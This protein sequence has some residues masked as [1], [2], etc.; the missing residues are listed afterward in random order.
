M[1]KKWLVTLHCTSSTGVGRGPRGCFILQPSGWKDL[2]ETPSK[3]QNKSPS[4]YTNCGVCISLER[5]VCLLEESFLLTPKIPSNQKLVFQ[6]LINYHDL[7]LNFKMCVTIFFGYE[8]NYKPEK[9][10]RAQFQVWIQKLWLI[11]F[12]LVLNSFS[13]NFWGA[14]RSSHVA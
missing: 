6:L 11:S 14:P 1:K 7:I 10:R 9:T 12:F 13:S 8:I 4:K 2:R 5:K 3:E